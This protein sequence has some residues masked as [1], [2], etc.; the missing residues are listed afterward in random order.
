MGATGAGIAPLQADMSRAAG[1]VA[2]NKR[3][4]KFSLE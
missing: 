3:I 1:A 4:M 2:A